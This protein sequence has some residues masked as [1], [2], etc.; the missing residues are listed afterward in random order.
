MGK[1]DN[2]SPISLIDLQ[3]QLLINTM[4]IQAKIDTLVEFII[5]I[6]AKHENSNVSKIS[7]NFQELYKKHQEKYYEKS[8]VEIVRALPE[9]NE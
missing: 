9:K 6:I 3:A 8:N 7:K 1:V 5:P 2:K 4:H